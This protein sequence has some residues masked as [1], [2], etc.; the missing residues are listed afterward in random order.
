MGRFQRPRLQ[1]PDGHIAFV[2]AVRPLL[3]QQFGHP[4]I[5][6]RLCFD[7][8]YYLERKNNLTE[9]IMCSVGVIKI[10]IGISRSSSDLR[11]DLTQWKGNPMGG[12][13]IFWTTA[14]L[15]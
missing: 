3:G 14:L 5:S 12:V 8:P 13:H 11:D 4:R 15:S 2:S 7:T 1:A 10:Y 6:T 9:V